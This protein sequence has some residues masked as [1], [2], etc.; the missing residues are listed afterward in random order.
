[1]VINRQATL[2]KTI[3]D[4]MHEMAI[5]F[6]ATDIGIRDGPA[7]VNHAADG[8][9]HPANRADVTA[10]V[11][12]RGQ[13]TGGVHLSAPMHAALGLA[14]AFWGEPLESFNETGR[15]AFGELANI[16]AGALKSRIDDGL[17]LTPPRI[18]QGSDPAD[19]PTYG[20][21]YSARCYFMTVNGPLYVEVFHDGQET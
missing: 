2:I 10:I 11:G 14:S 21:S 5:A 4:S 13:M 6:F 7:L 16:L 9:S 12:F 8:V 1:M 15:D 3:Q 19:L 17:D 20:G 18:V